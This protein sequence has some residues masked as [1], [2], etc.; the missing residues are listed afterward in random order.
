MG[1]IYKR[2]NT[3]HVKY[4]R[5]G[6]SYRESSHSIKKSVA[7]NLLKLRE[8][9]L[10]LGTFPGLKVDRTTFDEL[11]DDLINEYKMNDRKSLRRVQLAI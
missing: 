11:K 6:K 5:N 8:G 3:W 9:Q 1:S 10:Q 4:Y 7:E 2:G